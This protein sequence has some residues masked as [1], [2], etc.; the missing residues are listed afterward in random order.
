MGRPLRRR[1]RSL[2]DRA[3]ADATEYTI[4]SIDAS[5]AGFTD[6]PSQ[7]DFENGFTGGY[8]FR[9]SINA[10]QFANAKAIA[11]LADLSGRKELSEQ[12]DRK[13]EA[14]RAATLRELW[15]PNLVHFTD[16]Y[17]RSTPFVKAGTFIRG[18]E[19]AGF[20]RWAFELPPQSSNASEHAAEY[21][22]A[23]K[24]LL[25]K[26][27]LGGPF[28]LRTVEPT[29]AKYLQQYRYDRATGKPECQ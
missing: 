13:A 10:Y 15:N 16:V 21:N 22:A 5:G 20:V 1:P 12:Y 24:H 14:L 25:A 23:W 28:G 19:L 2:L 7:R 11:H 26:D 27:E 6:Q 29:Y 17:Q 3:L 9:P 8:S 4:S 18:R